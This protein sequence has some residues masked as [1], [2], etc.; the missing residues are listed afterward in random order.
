MCCGGLGVGGSQDIPEIL[1]SLLSGIHGDAKEGSQE[2]PLE[3]VEEFEDRDREEE[4]PREI[5]ADVRAQDAR[6]PDNPKEEKAFAMKTSGW[7]DCSAL[8]EYPPHPEGEAGEKTRQVLQTL[9]SK[10][11]T[12]TKE[13]K[14]KLLKMAPLRLHPDKGGSKEAMHWWDQ[15]KP[16]NEEWYLKGP[17]SNLLEKQQPAG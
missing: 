9:M 15:W 14:E 12:G 10:F 8:F 13:E 6:Q 7:A 17:E 4:P 11:S 1:A 3:G 2:E 16:N 5:Q